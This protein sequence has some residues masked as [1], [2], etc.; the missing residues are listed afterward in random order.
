[1]LTQIRPALERVVGPHLDHPAMLDLLERYPS[2]AHLA[3]LGE[4]QLDS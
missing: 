1:L 2:P 3:S 4:K